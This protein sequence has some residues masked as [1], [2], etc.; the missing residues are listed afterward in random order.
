MFQTKRM[1]GQCNRSEDTLLSDLKFDFI[2]FT[3]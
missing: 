1:C 3:C 2:L